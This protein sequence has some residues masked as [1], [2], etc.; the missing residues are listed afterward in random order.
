M[1]MGMGCEGQ[2]G[3]RVC[4]RPSPVAGWGCFARVPL[5][6]AAF[7]ME[8]TGEI[9]S[10]EE[11]ERRGF[12]CDLQKSNYFYELDDNFIVDAT[13]AGTAMRFCNHSARRANVQAE[14]TCSYR[15]L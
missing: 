4:I 12:W 6:A 1:R 10:Q 2:A 14:S 7:L 5:P 9:I 8:Y 13:Y 15:P 3:H 11:A